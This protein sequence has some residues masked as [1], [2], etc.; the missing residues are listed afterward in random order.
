MRIVFILSGNG[1]NIIFL[2]K[3]SCVR[4]IYF[5]MFWI[6]FRSYA[7]KIQQRYQ[8]EVTSGM[9]VVSGKKKIRVK[10]RGMVLVK[11]SSISIEPFGGRGDFTLWRQRVKSVLTREGT[12]KALKVKT[13]TTQKMTDNE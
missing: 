12:M 4:F 2:S 13:C 7:L 5:I 6:I 10:E 11:D 3:S 8:S 1:G 9:R